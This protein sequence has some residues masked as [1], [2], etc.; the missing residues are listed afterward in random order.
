MDADGT[1]SRRVTFKGDYNDGGAFHP[2][3]PQIV[4]STRM[5]N[6]FNLSTVDLVTLE[7][8]QL[9]TGP[10]S[11][12]NPTYSPDGRKVAFAWTLD[13]QKQVWTL[14]L[15]SGALKQ[16]TSEGKSNADP[17]WSGYPK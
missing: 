14:D 15:A 16:I 3:A 6:S 5:G 8:R 2:R 13:G 10:G 7:N 17:A 1:N 4:Y 12:E 11:K 9:T